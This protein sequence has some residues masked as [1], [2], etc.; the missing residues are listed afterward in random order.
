MEIDDTD[1]RIV[2]A[3]VADGR[4]DHSD[5]SAATGISVHVVEHRL[6]ALEREGVV[7][8]CEPQLDYDALRFDVT[9][10]FHLT[11]HRGERDALT[12]LLLRDDRL[13]T[14]YEVTGKYDVVAIGKFT[15]VTA[16]NE[17]IGSLLTAPSVRDASTA[18]VSE[19][20]QE[21]ARFP[22]DLTGE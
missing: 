4:A 22:V 12:D 17:R 6:E 15:S 11:A 14:V 8:D 2:N 20:G 1:R 7:G 18:V 19:V 5:I 9:A 16:L 13:L 3:L 21:H 10:V